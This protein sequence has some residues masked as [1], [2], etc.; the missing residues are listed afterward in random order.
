MLARDQRLRASKQIE[1]VFKRGQ[2]RRSNFF[3]LK[4]LPSNKKT[5]VNVVISAKISKKSVTRHLLKRQ[6]LES[7]KPLFLKLQFGSYSF[8]AQPGIVG[9]TFLEIK[10]D[11]ENLLKNY[12]NNEKS[13]KSNR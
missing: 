11:L 10:K 6:A 4:F 12:Q 3:Y 13:N 9:Q 2:G 1:A 7:I 5:L 8:V